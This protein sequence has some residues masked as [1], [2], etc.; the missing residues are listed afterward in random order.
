MKN[1]F[2]KNTLGFSYVGSVRPT[3]FPFVGG[4]EHG[5]LKKMGVKKMRPKNTEIGSHCLRHSLRNHGD[6]RH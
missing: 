4:W 1:N 6:G 2:T 3:E 5:I